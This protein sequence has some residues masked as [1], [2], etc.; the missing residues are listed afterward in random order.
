MIVLGICAALI[1]AFVN[2]RDKPGIQFV[3]GQL[4]DARFA[5]RGPIATDPDIELVLIEQSDLDTESGTLS[6]ARLRDG[7][8]TLGKL[9]AAAVVLDPRLLKQSAPGNGGKPAGDAELKALTRALSDANV[10]VPYV[11]SLAPATATRPALPPSVQHS[12]YSVLKSRSSS[13]VRRPVEAG[14]YQA[15]ETA[16]LAA[17][18]PGHMTYARQPTFSRQ[19]AYP[20]VGYG[21]AFY[22]SLAMQAF[23]KVTGLTVGDVEVTL[24][25][26]LQLDG[27]YLPTD[28]KMRLAVNYHGPGGSY[29]QT[30]FADLGAGG[31]F[32]GKLVIVGFAPSAR[33]GAFATPFDPALSEAEFLANVID[34]L[35]QRNPLIRSQQVIVLDILLL[36]L[37]GLFFALLAA[38]KRIVTVVIVSLIATGL[39]LIANIQAFVVFDLWLG[40]AFPLLAVLLSA[41][42]LVITKRLSAKREQAIRDADEALDEEYGAPWTFDRVAASPAGAPAVT[43]ADE[44][45][46]EDE[47]LVF[48]EAHEEP[49]LG[50]VPPRAPA[51]SVDLPPPS[52][53]EKAEPHIEPVIETAAAPAIPPLS[54][55]P[56]DEERSEPFVP[57]HPEGLDAETPEAESGPEREHEPAVPT[58]SDHAHGSHRHDYI[59]P[60][61]ASPRLGEAPPLK[62]AEEQEAAPDAPSVV[63]PA[64]PEKIRRDDTAAAPKSRKPASLI[65]VMESSLRR[66]SAP[67]RTSEAAIDLLLPEETSVAALF[68]R[69]RVF[70]LAAKRFGPTRSAQLLY[71]VYQLIEKTIVRNSGYLEQ[72]ADEDVMGVFGLPDASPQDAE[73]C[74]RAARELAAALSDW[75][76]RQGL[77]ADA[78]EF[79]VCADFG[80]AHVTAG[81][82]LEAPDV[83]LSGPVVGRVSRMERA[84]AAEGANIVVSEKLMRKAA[85]TE[86]DDD[87]TRGFIEQPMQQIP[88]V[89]GLTGLWRAVIAE[90]G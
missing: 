78:V 89:G 9:G 53:R 2:L 4:L 79:C 59:T 39:L 46:P 87:L 7:I 38:A 20:V 65:P 57:L 12:A 63:A 26:G 22:P 68:I 75:V 70:R 24:G 60:L 80:P 1:V 47:P 6:P 27:K 51:L 31:S 84:P 30:R 40:L 44:P 33:N 21:G 19:Y 35:K 11:F 41:A 90:E 13:K 8:A 72:F 73:N 81:G 62:L 58:E 85:E 18:S 71:S 50:H 49:V 67:P 25:E 43:P 83:S 23:L 48:T 15:P 66:E 69:M 64:A 56:D 61:P 36:A 52:V 3:E 17:G 37:I 82:T 28:S 54:P 77:P 16:I 5:L 29:K 14:G 86:K 10:I 88:G 45:R 74:L 55:L 34:N 32:A 76:R 42:V